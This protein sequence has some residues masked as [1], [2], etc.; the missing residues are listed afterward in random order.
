[1][2]SAQQVQI[3]ENQKAELSKALKAAKAL[4]ESNKNSIKINN[5]D[6]NV[7]RHLD[8]VAGDMRN[9]LQARPISLQKTINES[10]AFVINPPA[11]IDGDG[12]DG[13]F[14]HMFELDWPVAAGIGPVIEGSKAALIYGTFDNGIPTLG[15]LLAWHKQADINKVYVKAGDLGVLMKM[16]WNEINEKLEASG[17]TSQDWDFGNTGANAVAEIKKDGQHLSLLGAAFGRLAPSK[18]A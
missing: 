16:E 15:Y 2:A 14:M 11:R 7:R 4:S 3:N 5:S 1:M 17:E 9:T 8:I 13:Q 10:G 6:G 18:S 12:A